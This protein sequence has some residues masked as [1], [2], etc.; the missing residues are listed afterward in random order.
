METFLNYI[1]KQ[2]IMYFMIITM[3]ISFIESLALI[4]FFLPGILIMSTL[5]AAIIHSNKKFYPIW[6]A[7]IIGC[8][9]GDWISYFIGWKCKNLIKNLKI[10]Q[11]NLI[12]IKKVQKLL[13]K[14]NLITIF[15]GKFIG[16]TRPLIPILS[17]MLEISF[18]KKFFFPNL[19]SCIIWPI[20]YLAPGILTCIFIQTPNYSENN[21][22]KKFCIF[23]IITIFLS[24][25]II[26]Q[27]FKNKN[28]YEIIYFLK[29]NYIFLLPIIIFII[30]IINLLILQFYPEMI[31]LRSTIIKIFYYK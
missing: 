21:Y 1:S 16:I 5:G 7:S 3:C 10:F 20:I 17:G 29:K 28:Y 9:L 2:S 18:F 15:L 25:W 26:L 30:G 31:V 11:K 27:N 6:L 4:G 13:K 23:N 12:I 19:I 14:Y 8:L 24:L 22:F